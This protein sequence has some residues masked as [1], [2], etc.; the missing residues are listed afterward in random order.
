[1]AGYRLS[2]AI[3]NRKKSPGKVTDGLA[4][5][6]I[7][8]KDGSLT[9]WQRVKRNGKDVDLKVDTASGEISQQWL[10]DV[11]A[12]AFAMK[13]PKASGQVSFGEAWEDFFRSITSAE[14]SKWAESTAKQ[15]EARMLNHVAQTGLWSMPISSIRSADVEDALSDVKKNRPKLAPKVLHLIGQVISYAS[16]DLGIEVNAA[17]VLRE[18]LKASEKPVR[19]N[20]LPAITELESLRALVKKI[21]T[22]SL[23]PSTRWAL[24]LQAYT[25]QRSGEVAGAMWS[26]FNI[27]NG[28]WTIPRHRMKVSDW[29]LKPYDQR[30]ALPAVAIDIVRAIPKDSE[31]LFT[32][33]HGESNHI[34]VEAF[35]QAFQRLGFR[36]IATPHGWRSSLKTLSNDASDEDGRPL[37]S[38]RWVEDVLD[39][40]VKGVEAHYTRSQAEKGMA[41]VLAWWAEQIDWRK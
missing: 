17:K 12:K 24:L 35:S 25:C 34:S 5:S 21:E 36:G 29:S 14:N 30:I 19:M 27:E 10:S 3:I 32:P 15:S 11:R 4:L 23:Y 37:F 39:H 6:F 18:K 16:H 9:A 2:A 38:D 8:N 20:K 33:R 22:S 26:E 13:S 31:W 28:I 7:R 1:M 41:R 40:S